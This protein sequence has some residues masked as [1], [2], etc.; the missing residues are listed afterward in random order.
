MNTGPKTA[1]TY[2]YTCF[3]ALASILRDEPTTNPTIDLQ[4]K[5]AFNA[6]SQNQTAF[7]TSQRGETV[8]DF[9]LAK[10]H[11]P[12]LFNNLRT[13]RALLCTASQQTTPTDLPQQRPTPNS[14]NQN[15]AKPDQEPERKLTTVLSRR[16]GKAGSGEVT[17]PRS[18]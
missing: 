15:T 8:P 5:R 9:I 2:K 12:R 13:S 1:R 6:T 17:V 4:L 7:P 3:Q 14:T 11:T 10:R 18:A 16:G